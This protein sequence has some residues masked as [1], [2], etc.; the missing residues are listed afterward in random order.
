MQLIGETYQPI[1]NSPDCVNHHHWE[2]HVESKDFFLEWK[3]SWQC[4]KGPSF[5]FQIGKN[6]VRVPASYYIMIGDVYGEIDWIKV[7][8][9]VGRQFEAFI[10]MGDLESD[11]WQIE[12]MTVVDFL[13]DDENMYPHT[14]N[15][16]PVALGDDKTVL[17][18]PV[19]LYNRMSQY[20]FNDII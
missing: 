16:V 6:R 9:T 10:M 20:I 7:D 3:P 2:Y 8:E 11:T 17:V 13:D 15:P 19:D 1:P 4:I 12:S 14:K 18:S 5:V